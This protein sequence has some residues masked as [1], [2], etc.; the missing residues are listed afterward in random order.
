MNIHNDELTVEVYVRPDVLIEPIETKIDT[1][2]QLSSADHIDNLLL[3]AWPGAITLADK[4]PYS[5]AIDAF[6]QMVMW[7]VEHGVSI[8]PPFAVRT[9][10]STFTNQTQTRLQT[11]MMCLAVYVGEHLANVFPHSR[12]DDHH[13]VMDA[14]AALRADDLEL[15]PD[16]PESAAPPPAHCPECN[17]LLTNV[18]GM[19]ICQ[20]CDRVEVGTMPRRERS[21]RSRSILQ[22]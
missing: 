12:G 19:R 11:P 2:Q 7:A 15:F 14:I 10:T 18:Q 22:S 3:Y 17:T 20:E 16:V 8:Q 1:L 13:G 4:T 6:E 21:R 9:T 5:N